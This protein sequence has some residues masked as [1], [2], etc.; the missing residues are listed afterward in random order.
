MNLVIEVLKTVA[1]F[2]LWP[3]MVPS[4]WG[5]VPKSERSDFGA[6]LNA[7]LLIF[8]A[9]IWVTYYVDSLWLKVPFAICTVLFYLC[10]GLFFALMFL[11]VGNPDYEDC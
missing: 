3:A 6:T 8:A 4:V 5:E 10:C 2:L 7:V 1:V 11:I 9:L